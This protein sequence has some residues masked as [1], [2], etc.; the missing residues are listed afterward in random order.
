VYGFRG[1]I[2]LKLCYLPNLNSPMPA[3]PTPHTIPTQAQIALRIILADSQAVYRMGIQKIFRAR[4]RYP[5]DR[6]GRCPG[7]LLS[8][9]Q[10]FPTDVILL[11]S[12]LI[13]GAVDAIPDL[14]RHA[15]QMK[16]P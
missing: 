12:N 6:A 5:C 1:Q 16:I 11:E 13:S 10:R 2:T 15:P 9:I 3:C 7:G 4:R 8:G 14:V